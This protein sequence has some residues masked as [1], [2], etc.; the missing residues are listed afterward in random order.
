MPDTE[1]PEKTDEIRGRR[2][3]DIESTYLVQDEWADIPEEAIR[4]FI[5]DVALREFIS[6][7]VKAIQYNTNQKV[8]SE[9]Q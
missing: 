2:L 1:W 4:L 6:S 3:S 5:Q 9:Q 7:D 8:E